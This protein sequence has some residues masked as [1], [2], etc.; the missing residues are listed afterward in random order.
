M[1]SVMP[2]DHRHARG[3]RFLQRPGGLAVAFFTVSLG[4]LTIAGLIS[5]MAVFLSSGTSA[6]RPMVFLSFGVSTILLALGSLCLVRAS[7][8]V[9]WEKQQ[10]FRRSLFLAVLAGTGFLSVQSFG[11][12]MLLRHMPMSGPS[13]IPQAAFVFI[14]LH[15]VHMVVALLFVVWVFLKALT[16]RYDHEY[17]WGVTFCGWFW[18]G[19]GIVWIVLMGLFTIAASA[20]MPPP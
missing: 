16:D 14:A 5:R 20:T 1:H 10:P 17:S 6:G 18:H 12:T 15:A 8:F 11:L 7:V 9:R 2:D 4:L 13:A 3:E 19:L